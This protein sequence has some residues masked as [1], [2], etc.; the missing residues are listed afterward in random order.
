MI[1]R[2]HSIALV[3]ECPTDS[4]Q[5]LAAGGAHLASD[6]PDHD[7]LG[8][9]QSSEINLKKNK[10]LAIILN[11]VALFGAVLSLF[12][13]ASFA[14]LVRIGF[15]NT[16]GTITA[17]V[18]AVVLGLV[19]VLLTIHGLIHGFFFWVFTR[20]KPVFAVRL[21]Y[22]YAS[23]PDWYIPARQFTL[24]AVG[25]LVIIDAVGLLLMLL[26]PESWVMSVAFV[27][28]FNTGGSMGDL[29]VL[30]RLSKLSSTCLANDAGD[31]VTFY[32]P[33][34]TTSHP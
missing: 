24:A 11:V 5:Y 33:R 25:P 13:L 27:V 26:G 17:G 32:E 14:A 9:S 15:V 20:S 29:V 7:G 18:V 4:V 23:A 22:A 1:L 16:S 6:F 3:L 8:Y 19:L 28:A 2:I 21:S 12:L 10:R 31:V 34:S 30:T